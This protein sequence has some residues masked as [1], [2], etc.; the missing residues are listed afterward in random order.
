M[1]IKM[2]SHGCLAS[3]PPG[4]VTSPCVLRVC[5]GPSW[6]NPQRPPSLLRTPGITIVPRTRA[7]RALQP[8]LFQ[9]LPQGPAP[10]PGVGPLQQQRACVTS[11]SHEQIAFTAVQIQRFYWPQS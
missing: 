3:V 4:D 9:G 2:P 10:P 8:P 5:P 7:L 6:G 1:S 11:R